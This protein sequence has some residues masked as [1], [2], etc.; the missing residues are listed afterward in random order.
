M[1]D[2]GDG[3]GESDVVV[4]HKDKDKDSDFVVDDHDDDDDD[5]DGMKH[6]AIV[7]LGDEPGQ[8]KTTETDQI[9][10]LQTPVNGILYCRHGRSDGKSGPLRMRGEA[11]IYGDCHR[12]GVP[13]G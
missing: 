6:V 4:D 1:V 5:D 3:G 12:M 9:A 11:C 2:G 8:A 10:R 13:K 7:W